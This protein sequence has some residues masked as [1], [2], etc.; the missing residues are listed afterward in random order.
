MSTSS[1]AA[2][3][4][5]RAGV[6]EAQ[7]G[8]KRI[9]QSGAATNDANSQKKQPLTVQSYLSLL[10]Q[11]ILQVEKDAKGEDPNKLF[12]EVDTP[13]GSKSMLI[14]EYME[15]MDS[16][17]HMLAEE[18][19]NLKD[20][21]LSL[22]RYTIE[23]NQNLLNQITSDSPSEIS[24]MPQ[25]EAPKPK[26]PKT[27]SSNIE[28][29]IEEKKPDNTPLPTNDNKSQLPDSESSVEPPPRNPPLPPK[30]NKNSKKVNASKDLDI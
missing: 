10:E 20:I 21:V 11:R 6:T 4:R 27:T 14:T 12:V 23:V 26:E 1:L 22:Q 29:K 17:F 25:Y 13:T 9:E 7:M 18:I 8:A 24:P 15:D 28:L 16:R 3:K 2:A 5:R 30:I 19:T